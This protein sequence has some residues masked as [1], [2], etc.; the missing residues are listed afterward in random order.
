M[1]KIFNDNILLSIKLCI[2]F[3]PNYLYVSSLY[4]ISEGKL[5]NRTNSG[6]LKNF[7]ILDAN[8]DTVLTQWYNLV[9]KNIS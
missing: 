2:D 5:N 8:V 9:D 1:V 7:Q 6:R 4:D 3:E